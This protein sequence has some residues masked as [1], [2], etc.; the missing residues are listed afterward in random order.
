MLPAFRRNPLW[1][2]AIVH[3]TYTVLLNLNFI[4]M[5]PDLIDEIGDL[6][7][8]LKDIINKHLFDSDDGTKAHEKLMKLRNLSATLA[9]DILNRNE[10]VQLETIGKVSTVGDLKMQLE[11]L[12]PRMNIVVVDQDASTDSLFAVSDIT[13]MTIRVLNP[14]HEADE[15]QEKICMLNKNMHVKW[16]EKHQPQPAN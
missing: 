5:K 3:L 2:I 6:Y 9:A 14:N 13:S 15:H 16:I 11:C 10:F 7:E 4:K 1:T 8:G 12:D